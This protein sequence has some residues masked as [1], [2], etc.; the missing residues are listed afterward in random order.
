MRIK[1]RLHLLGSPRAFGDRLWFS[2][3][4]YKQMY[5]FPPPSGQPVVVG[6]LSFGGGINGTFN[7]SGVLT[8]GEVKDYWTNELG[9]PASQHP[10]VILRLLNGAKNETASGATVEL[11]ENTLDVE[12]IGG[13]CPSPTLTI[14]LYITGTTGVLSDPFIPLMDYILNTPVVVGGESL[15]PSILSCSWGASETLWG[16]TL[17]NSINTRFATAASRGITTC[18]ASGDW[19][20]NDPLTGRPTCLFPASSPHVLACGGSRLE[21]SLARV[22]DSSTVEKAWA[23]SGGGESKVFAKPS[24]QSR[25]TGSGRLVPDL[26]M[27]ADPETGVLFL[28]DGTRYIIGGT[29]IVAPAFAGYLACI[30]GGRFVLPRLYSAPTS[31]F[32]DITN[33][34]NGAYSAANGWDR[35]TGRG[36]PRA[37][38]LDG[39]LQPVAATALTLGASTLTLARSSTYQV[40]PTLTPV[41]ATTSVTWSSNNTKVV[42]V[43]SSGLI[44]AV[45]NGTATVTARSGSVSATVTVT[46]ITPVTGVSVSPTRVSVRLGRTATVRATVAP[47]TASIKDVIWSSSNSTIATVSASGVIT[48][49]ARGSTT[50]TVTTVYGSRVARVAVSVT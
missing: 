41:D 35:V 50:V 44:T 19:G 16:S 29:S 11:M 3:T 37:R 9:I 38:M 14:I 25:L 2:A 46:V 15:L 8:R 43:S 47:S 17:I 1:P 39:S 7:S 42:T 21:T 31:C 49:V 40:T 5:E 34:T 36:S 28:V 13:C 6:V 33:G 20:S 4:E 24:W 30:G 18:V 48:G 45:A 23:G 10:R 27:N 32:H 12:M 26:A 22:Y